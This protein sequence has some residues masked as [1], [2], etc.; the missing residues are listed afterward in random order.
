MDCPFSS[1]HTG[2]MFQAGIR[3]CTWKLETLESSRGQSHASKPLPYTA[4]DTS[5]PSNGNTT[6]KV[7]LQS[8][9]ALLCRGKAVRH[10]LQTPDCSPPPSSAGVTRAWSPSQEAQGTHTGF[11][12]THCHSQIPISRSRNTGRTLKILGG[13]YRTHKP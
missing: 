10:S 8:K 5:N 9:E 4:T 7:T 3:Q 2:I 13:G 6:M 11:Q 1:I 12:S